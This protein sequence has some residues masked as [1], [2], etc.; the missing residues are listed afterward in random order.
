M[1]TTEAGLGTWMAAEIAE[2]PR[3]LADLVSRAGEFRAVAEQLVR[4]RPKF[5]L[6]AARGS[7]D[8]A[9]LYGKYLVEVL[10]GLPAGLVSPSTTTLYGAEPDL[11]EVALIAVSQS[12]GSPDL[13][14]VT[15][16][17]ARRGAFTVAVTNTPD[18]P[19]GAVARHSLDIGA[20]RERAVA[21]TKT[22]SATLLAL[23]LLITAVRGVVPDSPDR[24]GELAQ[25]SLDD[26]AERG[27][28]AAHRLRFADRVI[29]TARGYSLAT[30]QEAA[31]K[32]AETSY[33]VTR[34]YS[35][36][37]LLHGPIAAVGPETAVLAVEGSGPGG[38]AMAEPLAALA[39][40]NADVLRIG[41]GADAGLRVPD[42]PEELSPVL[43]VLP[44]QR[45]AWEL[46]TSRGY[47]PDSPAGLRKVTE[48]R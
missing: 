12:G 3:V 10:L 23:N 14:E 29:T 39:A 20:G 48:T 33:L 21:A 27:V 6:F 25:A 16:Q 19:L 43:E 35:G 40:K 1:T 45:L 32:L 28:E 36:A 41:P 18:S 34:A 13:V 9:A 37:D 31:L 15:E 42:V 38:A 11:T 46:A 7:S 4:S 8:N 30:A 24:I 5:V 44:L 47:D 22:Y 2:Q 17:A 26:N